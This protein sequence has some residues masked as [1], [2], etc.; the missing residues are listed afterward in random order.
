MPLRCPTSQPPIRRR[1]ARRSGPATHHV[2]VASL[3]EPR[4]LRTEADPQDALGTGERPGDQP[5]DVV[6]VLVA[7]A[8]ARAEVRFPDE[9]PG[10]DVARRNR[11]SRLDQD[12]LAARVG[13]CRRAAFDRRDRGRLALAPGVTAAGR[14]ADRRDRQQ[15]KLAYVQSFLMSFTSRTSERPLRRASHNSRARHNIRAASVSEIELPATLSPGQD[16]PAGLTETRNRRGNS[17]VIVA[18]RFN[19]LSSAART[20]PGR[21]GGS[22]HRPLRRTTAGP[23]Q[24][25]HRVF[26]TVS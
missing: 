9:G 21:I 6:A 18:F 11:H 8:P 12:R 14:K 17:Q 13:L 2:P 16:A 1:V 7:E 22:A 19:V 20:G 10:E 15:S 25:A 5:H 3:D 24:L 26:G 4:L 23:A